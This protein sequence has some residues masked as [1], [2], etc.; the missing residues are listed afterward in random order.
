MAKE[1]KKIAIL[2]SGGDAPGM[3]AAV[4][5]I[6]DAAFS[7][8]L[9][10]YLVYEGYK[11]LVE[12][13]IKKID[14]LDELAGIEDQGGTILYTARYPQ[15]KE[16]EVRKRGKSNLDDKGID[17]LVVIGGDGS[18]MGAKLLS[19]LGVNTVGIPGTIDNDIQSSEFTLGFFTAIET[20]KDLIQ[21]VKDTAE[22]H[23]RLF[24]IETYG[25]GK[26]DL[27]LWATKDLGINILSIPE[28]KL[29]V[30]EI[31][32]LSRK[33][34]EAGKRAIMVIVAEFLYDAK[35]LSKTIEEKT[36]IESKTIIPLQIQRGGKPVEKDK[37]LARILGKYA[38][39]VLISGKTGITVGV[40]DWKPY[41][42]EILEAVELPKTNYQQMI[43]VY[44]KERKG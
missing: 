5:A 36:G 39:E 33:E 21:K 26:G 6:A 30:D 2:T 34:R 29:E 3:N 11:G 44:N 7:N 19:D 10:A 8:N 22:S 16:E 37:E 41:D 14:S 38:V 17:A 40:K 27:P 42:T 23:N 43:E 32:E 1:I 25:H 18:F 9:E 24:V 12:D 31:V 4:K 20:L 13:N 35:A 15:F 28:K